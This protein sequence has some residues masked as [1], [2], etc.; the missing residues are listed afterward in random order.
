MTPTGAAGADV[1]AVPEPPGRA[2]PAVRTGLVLLAL[3]FVSALVGEL[4]ESGAR[5]LTRDRMLPWILTRGLGL[6]SFT[7]LTA[8]VLTGIWLRHPWRSRFSSPHPEALLRVHVTLAAAV[9]TLLAGHLTATALD[10]YAGVGWVGVFLPWASTYRPTAI[11]LGTVSL[12]LVLLVTGTAA[13]AGTLGRRIWLPI[14]SVAVLVFFCSL[15]HALLAGSDTHRLRW[16]YAGAAALVALAQA[17]RWLSRS[18]HAD[19]VPVAR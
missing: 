12:Y 5:P 19:R 13:L 15:T 17:S 6:A 11:T 3:L 1:A 16:L 14:H 4:I 9:V 7:A 2:G 8:L 10:H 18:D